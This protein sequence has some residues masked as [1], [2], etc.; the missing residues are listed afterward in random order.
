MSENA[1]AIVGGGLAGLAAAT[2]AAQQ[3]LRVELFEQSPSLGGRAGSFLDSKTGQWIDHCRHVALGCCTNFLDF[4][5]RTGVDGCLER[6]ATLHFIGPDGRQY[7][8]TPSR[9]LPA[10]LGLLPGLMTLKY[11]SAGERWGI[12]RALGKLRLSNK[13]GTGSEPASGVAA[14]EASC[15]VPVPFL[16]DAPIETVGDESV[17]PWLR[18]QGQSERAIER[19]WSLVLVSALSETVDHASLA[20]ARTVFRTAFL[21]SRGASDLLLPRLPLRTLFHDRVGK[22]LADQGVLIHLGTPVRHIEGDRRRA[23]NLVL[24]DGT[25]REFDSLVVAVPW[26]N[27][28]SLFADDLWAAMPA[29][30]GAEQI[31]PGAITA[32]HLWFDR[33][34]TTLPHAVLVARLS[35]WVFANEEPHAVAADRGAVDDRGSISPTYYCQV[36]ISASH[37]L[38][39]KT[40]GELLAEVCRE[41]E[42]VWPDARRATLVHSRVVAQPAAV[43]S[44]VPG[45]DRLRPPQQTPIENLALAGD[46][47]AT[48]WPATMEGAVGSGYRA[49]EALLNR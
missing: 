24:A 28:R 10:P 41:L 15:E 30:A 40:H 2:A 34:I 20:A 4:C 45:V 29:A 49:V 11:L 12:I 42:E 21:G 14:E 48:G 25:R 23:R 7:D 26:R 46:W 47:T 35:Q 38:P 13:K 1:L 37:R 19:F 43:F 22:W 44:V 16:L 32:V 8:L 3:G 33:P 9:W 17:G 39:A 31:E 36:V 18:R 27:V 5:R 6:S